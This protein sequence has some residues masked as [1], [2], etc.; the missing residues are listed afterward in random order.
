MSVMNLLVCWAWQESVCLQLYHTAIKHQ[1]EGD[2]G[3]AQELYREILE[4]EVLDE[5][6]VLSGWIEG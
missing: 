4:S 3:K 6:R 1:Q 2:H 5:V